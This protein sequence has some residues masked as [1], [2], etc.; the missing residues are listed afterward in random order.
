MTDI[1]ADLTTT[2]QADEGVDFF[3]TIE[4]PGDEDWIAVTLEAGETYGITLRGLSSG[5]GTL[6]DPFIT[7]LYDADGND[8]GLSDDDGAGNRESLLVFTP[9]ESGTYYVSAGAWST[10]TGTYT[11]SYGDFVAVQ[12]TADS[13]VPIEEYEI[14]GDQNVDS[15]L[16]LI[17]FKDLI[18]DGIT[19]VTYSIP[20]TGS[21]YSDEGYSPERADSEPYNDISYLTPR[22]VSMFEEALG[23][24]S[25]IANVE[26]VEV[27][28][29]ATSAGTIRPAWTGLRGEDAAAWAYTPFSAPQSGDIW[30]LSENLLTG[31]VGSYFHLVMLHELG[32]AVGLKHPFEDDGSGVIIEDEYDGLEYTVMTY[33]TSVE[34]EAIQ[35]LSYYPTTYM[36]YDILALRHIYGEVETAP[37]DTTYVWADGKTYYET[38]W[39]TGGTD[40]YNAAGRSEDLHLN[41]QPGTWSNVGSP[42][43]MYSITGHVIR[44]KTETVFTPPE[45][46]IENAIGGTGDDTLTGNSADNLLVGNDGDDI[47]SG[48]SGNDTLRGNA[49][50]DTLLGGA[51]DDVMWAGANDAG[52]DSMNGGD[53][54]DL[55]GGGQGDDFLVGGAGT[56]VLFGGDG[57]DTLHGGD[58][59]AAVDV[60]DVT[61][62]Q[63][64][65]GGGDDFVFG[66]E[67]NDAIGGGG[68]DDVISAGAG[69][70]T[71]FAGEDGD[72]TLN[73]GADDDVLFGSSGDDVVAGD[74]GED[75]LFGGT[76]NDNV[77]GGAGDDT[78]YG[79][80]GDDTLNGGVGD[81]TLRAGAGED[82]LIFEAG[83]GNDTASGF[84]LEEDQLDLSA[85][86]TDFTDLAGLQAAATDTDDGVLLDLGGGD[87]LLLAGLAVSDLAA[88]SIA[89]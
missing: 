2:A 38:V 77:L 72:D 30:F 78:L 71:V 76:G 16:T 80:A 29:D 22:E 67:G 10:T 56:D 13:D 66:A 31:G 44:T 83:G 75:E 20:T 9:T 53:G 81:D 61:S 54:A 59:G 41:L 24:I 6:E 4:T 69:N 47:A 40:T 62:S 65:S 43:E 55:I 7:G 82:V 46:T 57:D 39:D 1:A 34:N 42:V 52:D 84:S 35:S 23:Q 33:T 51:G 14:S 12:M 48:G 85:T 28:D 19:T 70:D 63:L 17:R 5:S 60:T 79:G 32:H 74:G 11:L 27:A 88:A 26:F 87:S 8:L 49:G 68:G 58:F 21:V 37:G 25:D 15:L 50:D 73:G 36:Y 3:G 18:E 45:V 86:T 64:W 89:F